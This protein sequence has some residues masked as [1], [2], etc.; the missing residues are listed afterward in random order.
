M[1]TIDL[2]LNPPKPHLVSDVVKQRERDALRQ[3]RKQRA[4]AAEIA[5]EQAAESALIARIEAVMSHVPMTNRQIS[6]ACDVSEY[7]V[8]Q[9]IASIGACVPP[10]TVGGIV[11]WKL[12]IA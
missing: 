11:R 9:R 7:K 12:I 6:R 10:N 2:L 3:L 5:A 1:N 4:R 8:S